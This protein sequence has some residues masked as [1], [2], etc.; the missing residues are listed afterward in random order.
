LDQAFAVGDQLILSLE[1][2]VNGLLRD[3]GFT[4]HVGDRDLLEP[5]RPPAVGQ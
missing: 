1:V 5:E 4:R 3:L 2:A